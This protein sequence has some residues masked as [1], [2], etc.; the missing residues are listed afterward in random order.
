MLAFLYASNYLSSSK[1]FFL[2]INRS[3]FSFLTSNGSS[4]APYLFLDADLRNEL[5]ECLTES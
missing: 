1:F 2:S 4:V 3:S 5:V